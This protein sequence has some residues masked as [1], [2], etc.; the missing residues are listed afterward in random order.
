[1]AEKSFPGNFRKL[2][3]D[4]RKQFIKSRFE[5]SAEEAGML[6]GTPE[7]GALADVMV[8][9]AVGVMPVPLGIAYG[10]VIDGR[11]TAIP[12]AC[13]E[14]SV[15]AA[16]TYA[17]RIIRTGGGFFTKAEEPLMTAQVFLEN[18]RSDADKKILKQSELIRDELDEIL[19]SLK[20]RGGG[21]RKVSAER[22]KKTGLLKTDITIDVRDAMGANILNT[23][24]EH[25][26]GFLEE[27][28]GGKSLMC[29]LSNASFN[30]RAAAD[31]SLPVS[32]LPQSPGSSF[33]KQETAERIVL[34]SR[35]AHE[36]VERAVT[37]NKGIM[38]GIH[39]LALATGNDTRALEGAV[40]AYASR[41]GRYRSLSTFS[42][43][44][45]SLKGSLELPLPLGSVGGAVSS[46]PAARACMKILGSPGSMELARIGAALGLA[47]NFSALLALVTEGIQKGH[48]K[49]H[50]ERVAYLAGAK[51]SEVKLLADL[52]SRDKKYNLDYAKKRLTEL[53]SR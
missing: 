12:I 48:M 29:I 4:E 9:T 19:L 42:L 37:H 24:V 26:R 52:L 39:A 38:N 17:A 13:E 8:E 3:M 2:S 30:R 43:E 53:R 1:M 11:E 25:L 16:A 44:G 21:F 7:M 23:A 15:I 33:S 5:L 46:H 14:P 50:A 10:F 41:D 49:L 47:Q 34:A 35:L 20:K 45:S 36:D 32:A 40:H 6:F 27:M 28:T 51:G 18:C 22:L 31:F